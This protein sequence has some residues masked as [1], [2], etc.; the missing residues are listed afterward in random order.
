MKSTVFARSIAATVLAVAFAIPA[1]A[2]PGTRI[3]VPGGTALSIVVAD[4]IS[5][6]NANVGDTFA[7]RVSENVV[8]NGWVAITKGA[9]GQGKIVT[10]DRAGKH[11]HPGSL[12]VQMD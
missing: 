9:T 2:G 8:V 10:V 5:S 1:T 7:I 12:G 4:K 11:G 6:A 3:V